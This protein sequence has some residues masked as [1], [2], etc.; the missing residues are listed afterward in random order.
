MLRKKLLNLVL[1]TYIVPVGL[2]LASDFFESVSPSTMLCQQHSGRIHSWHYDA[3][4]LFSCQG[5]AHTE[6]RRRL[7]VE[8]FR[9]FQCPTPFDGEPRSKWFDKAK[10]AC[11]QGYIDVTV[12]VAVLSIKAYLFYEKKYF[13]PALLLYNCPSSTH[14]SATSQSLG[15]NLLLGR[16]VSTEFR[17]TQLLAPGRTLS[18]WDVDGTYSVDSATGAHWTQT[19]T[20]S[21]GRDWLSWKTS[22]NYSAR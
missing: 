8:C 5:G 22:K 10:K 9:T 7:N 14:I 13:T 4:N 3:A 20:R 2:A 19:T 15:G 12:V 1:Y 17:R 6:K 11:H 18:P 21:S 16:L